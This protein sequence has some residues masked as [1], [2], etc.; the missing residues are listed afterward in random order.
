M[1][2]VHLAGWYLPE[3]LGGTELYVDALS[4]W[5]ARAG[6]E[7]MV[8]APDASGAPERT[9][10]HGGIPVYRFPVPRRVTRDEAQG[11]LPVRGADRLH[12]WLRAVR[13]DIAHFHGLVTGLGIHEVEAAQ[14]I[15]ARTVLTN[16]LPSL[17]FLCRRGTWMRW[18]T[19]PCEGVA[20][21]ST[22]A[23]CVLQQR[24][25]SP[26]LTSL[27]AG[28]PADTGTIL[29]ALPGKIGTAL[30][31][32]ASI[33]ADL[34]RQRE[35]LNRLDAFVVLNRWAGDLVRANGLPAAKV[36]VNRL[37]VSLS[38]LTRK[39]GPETSPTSSPITVGFIGRLH[40]I[41]GVDILLRAVRSLDAGVAIRLAVHGPVAGANEASYRQR[42]EEIAAGDSR[43]TIGSPLKPEEVGPALARF[44]VLC[45]P[46]IS[47]ENGPTVALDAHA[48]G[49]PVI[50]SRVG[51]L[52]EIVD[53][54]VNGRLFA[55]GDVAALAS[56][57]ADLSQDPSGTID[58]WR[59][60]L[61]AVRT[62]DDVAREYLTLYE[63][64]CPPSKAAAWSHASAF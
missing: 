8:A 23:A 14:S 5:L 60:A 50:G 31:L 55:A 7:V 1:R 17:G 37:G 27:V 29:G 33:R 52:P 42:L 44:D 48:V 54:G 28:L 43:I 18:G 6:H 36:L 46:S 24:G 4:R 39:P 15:G 35:L 47:F 63:R 40:E 41:K 53:D 64:L 59:R 21:P 26:R 57:L 25:L 30:G 61:P 11:N 19:R 62:M 22:C 2:V 32:T 45:C 3:S 34:M 51:A 9:Y 13:P 12:R 56:I 58:R 20:E 10:E 38:G 16:H 49:T